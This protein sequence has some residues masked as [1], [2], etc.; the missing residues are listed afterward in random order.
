MGSAIY[1]ACGA[2][3][4]PAAAALGDALAQ[5]G[6]A[7]ETDRA[8]LSASDRAQKIASCAAVAL[9]A[10]HAA[11]DSDAARRD[12]AIALNNGRPLFVLEPPDAPPEAWFAPLRGVAPSLRYAAESVD[13]VAQ[14]LFDALNH[15]SG[16]GRTIAML[17]I[18]G[19]VGKTVLAANLFA[20]AHL[21]DRRAVAF[22]D[23][24]PQHNL[25]QYFLSPA[26]RNRLRDE[27]R[28]IYSVLVSDAW[29]ARKLDALG[30]PLNRS[31]G[32]ERAPFSLI[33]GDERLFEF[34]LDARSERQRLSAL[35][36][37]QA[38]IGHLR[39]KFD[40][41]V[42]DANPC[43]TFL[44]RLAVAAAD[45]IVAPV[46][47][48]KYSLTGLNMLEHVVT[49]IRGLPLRSEDV[50][51]LLNGVNDRVRSRASDD[52]D[53]MTRDE[54]A[55]AP[56][57]GASLLHVAIPYSGALKAPPSDRFAPNPI[58]VTAMMRVASREAKTAL[59][60]AAAAV[61]RRSRAGS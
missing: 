41:I 43:A 9:L 31:R 15:T 3:D 56:L 44:T 13:A 42:I 19:G 30:A 55:Q 26:E 29:D 12:I 33:A 16:S 8:G 34:T 1:L 23:L 24:D 45:H 27:Q 32:K 57:F 58:N 25:T 6:I 28:T 36:R 2:S 59:V 40:A 51:V 20:A 5:R 54:I 4:S 7:V 53:A 39:T 61:L 11:A 48:E 50:S 10:T 60:E 21:A 14:S 49:E 35:V 47:P 37:F 17:N 38:L 52:A 46:R 18:K 22:V